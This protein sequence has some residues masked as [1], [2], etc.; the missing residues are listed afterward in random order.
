MRVRLDYGAD[1]LEVDLPDDRVTIIEPRFRASLADPHAALVAALRAPIGAPPLR[2]LAS[3]GGRVAISVCDI[4]R[5]QPRRETL[6]ALFE[7]MPDVRA[8][9][10][11]ILIATGT[12]RC[13]TPAEIEAM[14]GADIMRRCRVINHD[15]RDQSALV[16]VGETTTGV[17]V[18]LNRRWLSAD[19]RITTGFVEPHFFAGFS[20][21][22]KMVAPGLAGLETTLTLHDARRIGDPMATW[23]IT[24]GNPIHDDIREIARMTGV[25]FAV[26]VTLNRAQQ[27]TAVFAGELFAEHRAACAAAKRDAMREVASPFDVVLTTNS[28]YPLDQNLYQAVKGMSAAAKVV[29]RGGTI[30]CAAECRD[31]LPAHGSYGEVL[32]SRSS[33]QELLAM[34]TAPGYSRPDQWQVQI[35]AQ[36]QTKAR[37]LVKTSGLSDGEI[38][39]AHFDPIEEVGPAV[40]RALTAAGAQATL[41]VLPQ[42]PQTIPYLAREES[43]A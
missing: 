6:E 10:V 39:A 14:L 2:E 35:Q 29:K 8:A 31:G 7:E 23:G 9:D 16:H 18:Y 4:T 21:G 17:P 38:R 20:G 3:R 11:T 26:D 25:H 34:I 28:G 30:V 42:G 37:V 19:V 15:S 32:A 40:Q 13:N 36:V 27:I 24:E 5:A 12:H 22:P 41:C 33:P 1:G 43:M